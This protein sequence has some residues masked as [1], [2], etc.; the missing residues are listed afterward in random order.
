LP[1]IAVL[2]FANF[3]GDP[4]QDYFADGL[5]E[6]LITELSRFQELHVIARNSVM[7]Y[8]G[9]PVR[10]QEVGRDLGVRYVLEGSVR[11]AGGRVRITAQ[12]I[13]A[14]SGHHLWAERFDRDL[15]DIFEVQDE[16]TSRIVATLAGKLAESERRRARSGQTENLEAYDC[17]LRGRELWE[18]FTPEDNREARRLYEKAIELDPDYARA[19]AG[20]AWTYLVEHWERWVGPEE[21]PLERALEY[22]R[23]GVAVNRAS[24][25][26]HLALGQ[27][28]L[29][30]GLYD[31]ALEAL[32]TAIALNPNDADGYAFLS[33]ALSFAGRPDEA[34]E[35]IE[36]A[37]RLNPAAPRW[38]P[39]NLGIA[40]YLARR[41][42][43]AVTALRRARPLGGVGYRW[44]AAAYS[45]LGREQEAK[46]A[47][48]E[49][50]KLTPDFSLAS[51]LGILP[52]QHAADREH[53]AEGLRKAG[54]PE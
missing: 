42:D 48:E 38:Y 11:K 9:K 41:Y 13:D 7:T 8:K 2:P 15:A 6:D 20:L 44:L 10:V 37:Q 47:A 54:F 19:Y 18:R 4:E 34:I 22:A 36:K 52:F 23:Q 14:A 24:H 45:Q 17:V 12:L 21:Q 26:N 40:L 16:V 35:L 32:E 49:Y 25:S 53:Y 29:N 31:E 27:V 50:L 1:S 28:C 30:K 33:R 51:H 39:W 3:G 43:D 46:A 5:T